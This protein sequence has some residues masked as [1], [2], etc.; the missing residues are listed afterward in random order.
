MADNRILL[1]MCRMSGHEMRFIEEAF[2]GEWVVPLG[3]N[4][5]GF[6]EDLERFL[7][8]GRHVVAL[9]S[10]TAAIH[11][12]LLGLGVKEGDEVMVQSMTFSASVNPVRYVGAIPVMVDSEPSTWNIDPE[13]LDHAIEDRVRITGKKPKAIIAVC[14]YGMPA[15]YDRV[16]EVAEKWDIPVLEDAAEAFGSSYRERRC[17]TF[18]HFGALSFNGNKM[19]T[20]SGGGALVCP[21]G[22][23]AR[24]AMYY[25]TQARLGYAYYQH[26]EVG[27]NYRMSNISAGIGRG[28]MIVAE[29][30]IAH[31]RHRQEYYRKHLAEIAGIKLH[32]NPDSRFDSNF[33]LCTALIDPDLKVKGQDKAYSSAITST[34]GGA[35]GVTGQGESIHTDCEPNANVEGLRLG[36]AAEGIE[37]RPLWKPMH[38]QPVFSGFPSYVNGVSESLFHRGICL[39]SGPYVTDEDADRVIRTIRSLIQ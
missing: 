22:E 35:G 33:W 21:D 37:S 5:K 15:D 7:G 20:T 27:Y 2:E 16:M 23:S 1:R 8:E 36:L 28:Q 6:E 9:S 29:E 14:L 39:P 17:G 10:G 32:D 4:V 11:L 25:A 34:V 31:H 24:K 26:E 13:L 18:G 38:R 30:Y 12:G 3:P 19:I